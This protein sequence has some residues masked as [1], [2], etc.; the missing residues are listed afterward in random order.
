MAY[1]M[2]IDVGT[3]SLKTI[4]TDEAGQMVAG[5]GQ[6]YQFASP[7]SGWAEQAPEEWWAA[8]VATIRQVLAQTGIDSAEIAGVGFSGQM[9]GLVLLDEAGN[10]VRPSILHCDARTDAQLLQITG[11]LGAQGVR[12]EMMN[13]VFTG[14]LLPSLLWVRENEPQNYAKIAKVCLPKDYI[15][16]RLCGEV[17]SD[18]SDAGATLAYD[19]KHACWNTR[20]L[21]AFGLPEAWFSPCYDSC[22]VVGTVSAAAA[23]QTGL[24]T[25]TKVVAGGGDQA[26]QRLGSGAV[27]TTEATVNIG[28]SGQVC[29]QST[30]P[31]LNP[32]LNT[33]MFYGYDKQTWLVYGAIM[34]A[35]LCLKWWR[36]V[37]QG[38][39]YGA[40]DESVAAVPPGSGGL[41]FLPYL[42]GERTPHL[43]PNISGAFLGLNLGSDCARMSRAVMEGVTY[44]L[45]QCLELCE[46]M[47]LHSD[48]LIASGGGAR[49]SVWRQ[50]QADVFGL[51]LK[52]ARLEEQACLGA[53]ICAAV[54]CGAYKNAVQ[55]CAGMVRYYDWLVEPNEANH[56]RY[57]QYYQ[58][59]KETYSSCATVL[60]RVTKMGREEME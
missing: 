1:Y 9:H 18:Y 39:S 46:G 25:K 43:N 5:C 7:R 49:S 8:A 17:S 4:L 33:N 58:L 23:K 55:A 20:V 2:G 36:S 56:R 28:T 41:L 54:G 34:N 12:D 29:F 45:Y 14:F 13:P 10:P 15:K 47:G 21:A 40:L 35:G 16:F 51:P 26:M 60:E 52:M 27:S 37:L 38:Q 11:T 59:F 48:V 19:L 44:A 22:D 57:G 6:N 31:L 53:C 50:I 3:S 30:K 32:A 24:C 42:N